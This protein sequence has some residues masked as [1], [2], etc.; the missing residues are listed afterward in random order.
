[1]MRIGIPGL[2]TDDFK[3]TWQR[4]GAR[5]RRPRHHSE[6]IYYCSLS[7]TK[8]GVAVGLYPTPMA[9]PIAVADAGLIMPPK[10]TW[11]E[12]KLADGRVNRVL[13]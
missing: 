2:Q 11:F 6:R 5:G 3:T 4:A 10:S 13:D 7:A 1:M 12:P 8:L 9:S